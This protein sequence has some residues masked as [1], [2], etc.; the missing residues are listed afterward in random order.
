MRWRVRNFKGVADC[1]LVLEPGITTILTG[2]NSSGKT[3][4]IQSLLLIKQTGPT[5]RGIVL[6]GPLVRL[7]NAQDLVGDGGESKSIQFDLQDDSGTYNVELIP[8]TPPVT[9]LSDSA[10]DEDSLGTS[11]KIARLAIDSLR[12]ELCVELTHRGIRTTDAAAIQSEFPAR[13]GFAMLRLVPSPQG[14][15]RGKLPRTYAVFNGLRPAFLVQCFAPEALEREF[16]KKLMDYID[17]YR[18]AQRSEARIP[19]T[20]AFLRNLR[21]IITN[22]IRDF[23][24]EALE[25]LTIKESAANTV[26]SVLR[27]HARPY[28]IEEHL[29]NF[30][31]ELPPQEVEKLVEAAAERRAQNPLVVLELRPSPRQRDEGLMEHDLW[32]GAAS[33]IEVLV[34]YGNGIRRLYAR[35]NYLGPLRDEP[36]VVWGQWNSETPGLP[37]GIKGE[38]SASYLAKNQHREVRFCTPVDRTEKTAT[39]VDAT[40]MW[41]DHLGIGAE[42]HPKGHGKIGVGLE[43]TWESKVRDL[44]SVGVGVSQ[45]LPIVLAGLAVPDESIFVVEQPELHLHPDVQAKLA[46]FFL[47]ARPTVAFI[48]ETHSEA[49]VT[50]VRRRVAEGVSHPAKVQLIFVEPK[51][52]TSAGDQSSRSVSLG[53]VGRRIA[54]TSTGDFA[55]WPRGFLS[56]SLDDAQAILEANIKRVRESATHD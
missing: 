7:G 13:N 22:E 15:R 25:S 28:E 40:S 46:D 14:I 34:Q 30:L 10:A 49:F 54:M 41:L 32:D 6:N 29:T 26:S 50:R 43:V 1:A 51:S 45:A 19:R 8:A 17:I 35:L 53:A 20:S 47:F 39:L 2:V 38:L 48:I 37:V 12:S 44:T 52:R 18:H 33:L 16:K 27:R 42:V 56:G 5:D 24:P 55:E 4:I 11:L 23:A 21:Q 9:Q 3:S 31:L 36:R